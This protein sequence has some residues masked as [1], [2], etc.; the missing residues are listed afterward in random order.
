M[1]APY[2]GGCRCQEIRFELRAEPVV[3]AYCHCRDCQL[4]TGSA[5]A[6]ILLAPRSGFSV[7]GATRSYTVKGDSGGTVT[8]HFCPECGSPL[9]S[10][11]SANPDVVALKAGALDDSSWV[12][13]VVEVWTDSSQPWGRIPEGIPSFP[14]NPPS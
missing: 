7:K 3:S 13:P 11:I 10:E 1:P 4:S 12:R 9:Y 14:K 5:Y 8:R 6:T 2:S